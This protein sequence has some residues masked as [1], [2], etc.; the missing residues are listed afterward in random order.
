MNPAAGSTAEIEKGSLNA[1]LTFR[2]G[3]QEIIPSKPAVAGF[4]HYLY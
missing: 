2:S 3:C 4:S 1:T